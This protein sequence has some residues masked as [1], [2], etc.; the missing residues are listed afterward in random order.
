MSPAG[1]LR[2]TPV[3]VG[4]AERP[5]PPPGPRHRAALTRSGRDDHTGGRS[6]AWMPRREAADHAPAVP[7]DRQRP[8]PRL[9]PDHQPRAGGHRGRRRALGCPRRAEGAAPGAVRPAL[10]WSVGHP[11]PA[12]PRRGLRARRP[13]P[14]PVGHPVPTP[15][16]RPPASCGPGSGAWRPSRRWRACRCSSRAWPPAPRRWSGCCPGG[17]ARRRTAGNSSWPRRGPRA[18][19]RP[20]VSRSRPG[21]PGGNRIRPRTTRDRPRWGSTAGRRRRAGR[22]RTPRTPR[23]G[24]RAPGRRPGPPGLGGRARQLARRPAS[25]PGGL[26]TRSQRTSG[27]RRLWA[28]ATG[29]SRLR[30]DPS[31]GVSAPHSGFAGSTPV[32][33]RLG[34]ARPAQ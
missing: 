17:R 16:P 31:T 13:R 9:Q 19:T 20:A 18:W 10:P 2:V 25:Q 1:H 22:L 28:A 14:G 12:R 33:S 3:G 15:D 26:T 5:A 27:N 8:G 24:R 6:C 29:K 23:G 34:L 7:A 11:V 30:T 32:P 21:G 4:R